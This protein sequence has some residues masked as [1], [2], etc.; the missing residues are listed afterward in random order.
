MLVNGTHYRTLWPHPNAEGAI[1]VIDQRL[2]PHQFVVLDLHLVA[3]VRTAIVDMAVRGAPLIAVTA[4]YG[5]WLASREL[6]EASEPKLS[7]DAMRGALR[8]VALDLQHARPTA[9]NVYGAMQGMLA[10]I[11]DV[12][13]AADIPAALRRAA[14]ELAEAEAERCRLIGEAGV[15]LLADIY[16]RTGQ[17]VQVLTHCNA[18]WL[19][20]VDY[21]TAPAPI[22]L[23][24]QQGIP[25]HVWVD[26]TRP[27]NQGASLT[28]WELRENGV[29]HTVIV[30]NMGGLLMQRGQVDLCLVGADRVTRQGWVVNKIGTYLKALAAH[31]HQVPF[32]VALPA[33]T[34]DWVVDDP[35]SQIPIEARSPDE[36]HFVQG[37][38]ADGSVQ[39]VRVTPEG[40]PAL[41]YGFDLTPPELVSG[42]ITERGVF[43]PNELALRA[44]FADMLPG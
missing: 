19:G 21:G 25:V 16:A 12:S 26:E 2:L 7:A 14:D 6:L 9:V 44:A 35:L 24:Q 34:F 33:T 3:Q 5:L 11:A 27:R 1:Q 15:H 29:P 32:Y 40:S 36:V 22:Y 13:D 17:P 31:A 20:C 38:H 42:L 43:P 18:G 30:D 10:A 8:S 37:L 39:Q 4:S 23:A 41:N 28:A